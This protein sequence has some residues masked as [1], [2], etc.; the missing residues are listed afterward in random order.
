[1]KNESKEKRK[2]EI[3]K[4]ETEDTVRRYH[5]SGILG[6]EKEWARRII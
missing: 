2:S 1:M 6:R 3:R 5:T 4:E